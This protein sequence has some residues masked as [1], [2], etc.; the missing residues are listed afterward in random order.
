MEP[1][2]TSRDN[3]ISPSR[4]NEGASP[5]T[6]TNAVRRGRTRRTRPG[7]DQSQRRKRATA[8]KLKE[9]SSSTPAANN[10]AS[11]SA[12][13][14]TGGD[15][16]HPTHHEEQHQDEFA[17]RILQQS[18]VQID[19][20]ANAT[21]PALADIHV[22]APPGMEEGLLTIIMMVLNVEHVRV[23]RVLQSVQEVDDSLI[24]ESKQEDH[25]RD[26]KDGRFFIV[27]HVPT[28]SVLHAEK[29]N[30]LDDLRVL[31]LSA[32]DDFVSPNRSSKPLVSTFE[33]FIEPDRSNPS[34]KVDQATI[35]QRPSVG[36][37]SLA[38]TTTSTNF[39]SSSLH[40]DVLVEDEKTENHRTSRSVLN[41]SI[42]NR[43]QTETTG[44]GASIA[45]G[46]VRAWG[47]AF[48]APRR[49]SRSSLSSAVNSSGGTMLRSSRWESSRRRSSR[50]F[51][52]TRNAI[53]DAD[54]EENADVMPI[55]AE[56]VEDEKDLEAS[57][58]K[59]LIMEATPASIVSIGPRKK[60]IYFVIVLLIGS[61]LGLTVGLLSKEK[62]TDDDLV[63]DRAPSIAP[64]TSIAP[65]SSPTATPLPTL[66][67][68]L[69]RG[70][71]RCCVNMFYSIGKLEKRLVS[72]LLHLHVHRS[73]YV[74]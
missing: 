28:S 10:D 49:V 12:T 66:T 35:C 30:L 22:Q 67:A 15:D 2:L 42:A 41:N 69:E 40:G 20:L 43:S 39:Q 31:L 73:P 9:S 19:V 26:E 16:M 68:I 60:R 46:A 37:E 7:D 17:A 53:E 70:R 50:F 62:D 74:A 58:R 38:N 14:V 51:G 61:I 3:N 11:P 55:A 45:P 13:T 23:I 21:N 56:V 63:P 36:I 72:S 64:T 54:S 33:N 34:T 29:D 57:I 32:C 71:I 25:G 27:V 5:T 24:D 8:E 52:R 1:S 65:S 48:G 44:G 6:T 47:R 4:H 59:I 18:L